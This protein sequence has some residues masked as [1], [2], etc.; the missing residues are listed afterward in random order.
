MGDRIGIDELRDTVRAF[1]DR[2][3]APHAHEI[4]RDDAFPRWLWPRMG[5]LGVLADRGR[6]RRGAG[7]GF[8]HLVVVEE[9]SRASAS[10]G[11]SYAAHSNLCVHNLWVNGTPE[12]HARWLPRLL[13][14]EHVGALAMSEADA[15]SDVI[16]S[17]SC[18]AEPAAG[19]GSRTAR[20]CGSRTV[21]EADVLIVYMR[22]APIDR[23]RSVTAFVI[24]RGMDGFRASTKMDKLGMRGSSTSEIVFSDCHIPEDHV[25]GE[26]GGGTGVLMSGL[27]SER[28]V[29][30]GGPLGIMQAAMDL[31]LPY[32]RERRQ[33][34]KP[35]GSFE[36]M[37]GKLAD[38]YVSLESARA[39]AYDVAARFDRDPDRRWSAACAGALLYGSERPCR[40]LSRPSRASAAPGT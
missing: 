3:V 19:G 29:L 4:D 16:G 21:L 8:E 38:M 39:Y 27:D 14:G 40:L 2:E 9:L 25:L 5:D 37:Q 15:G 11:M 20:R 6:R 22:T 36:L 34:G 10:V 23:D 12:Q 33:F 28:L 26:V 35:I 30:A 18:R 7:L 1:A 24:E 31:V 32:V 17:M 13:S